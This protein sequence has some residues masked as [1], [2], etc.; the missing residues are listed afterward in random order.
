MS[1]PVVRLQKQLAA[2]ARHAAREVRVALEALAAGLVAARADPGFDAPSLDALARALA[3]LKATGDIGGRLDVRFRRPPLEPE[4]FAVVD[5]LA[6]DPER[7]GVVPWIA[8]EEA[9][10]DLRDRDPVGAARLL[11]IGADVEALYGPVVDPATGEEVYLHGFAAARALSTE[12]AA[13]VQDALVAGLACGTPTPEVVAELR[14]TW[15]WPRAYSETVVRTNYA[16]ATSAG[17]F[18]E[19]EELRGSGIPVGF[20]FLAVLDSDTRPGHA[21]LHGMRARADDPVWR[22]WTPPLSWNCRC[23]CSP[24]IGDDVPRAFVRLPTGAEKTPGFGGRPDLLG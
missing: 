8:L 14:E 4:A 17:R 21:A 5:P 10:A 19:A 7:P 9:V 11:A 1:D 18:R 24:L 20:E 3:R 23:V 6:P 13:R 15:E 2:V 22:T 12:A 16:T